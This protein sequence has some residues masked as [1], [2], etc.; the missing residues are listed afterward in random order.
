MASMPALTRK[1]AALLN[2]HGWDIEY[3]KGFILGLVW[4]DLYRENSRYEAFLDL[5]EGTLGDDDNTLLEQFASKISDEIELE[6]FRFSAGCK[7]NTKDFA[8]NYRKESKLH[9]WA[10]GVHMACRILEV[11][12]EDGDVLPDEN[13]NYLLERIAETVYPFLEKKF[14]K[15]FFS[16][17]NERRIPPS[18]CAELLARLRT[19]LPK[20]IRDITIS[21]Q[22]VN[23]LPLG[24]DS[25]EQEESFQG[26]LGNIHSYF[27]G[28]TDPMAINERIDRLLPV[29]MEE[30]KSSRVKNAEILH[31]Y[32]EKALG[33]EFFNANAGMFWG[34]IETRTYM[35]VLTA[36]AEAYRTSMQ[37][38]KAVD[39]YEKSLQLCADDNLGA[40][41]LL[42]DLYMELRRVEDALALIDRFDSDRGAM[43]LFTKAL[44]LFMKLGDSPKA[45]AGLKAAIKSNLHI[46]PMLLNQLPMPP[47]LPGYYSPGGESEAALYV[48]ENRLLWRNSAGAMEWLAS[49]QS[50]A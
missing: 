21:S 14:A 44:A 9:Q 29:V 6:R 20:L 42:A 26:P 43:M 22:M 16:E 36:L 34:L 5:P 41:Y 40:R 8:A 35:R 10:S 48:A 50:L 13:I 27:A 24:D 1:V 15:E 46:V 12:I 17:L 32:A 2:S 39:C 11:M 45:K 31:R 30:A 47:E 49:H 38:E 23:H 33:P 3:F 19:D 18:E 4:L 25:I 37:R 28:V 7:V